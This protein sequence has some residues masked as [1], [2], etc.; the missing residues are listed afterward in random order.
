MT[1]FFDVQHLQHRLIHLERTR[2]RRVIRL[3]R[4]RPMRAGTG[5][6]GTFVAQVRERILAVM[7]IFPIDLESF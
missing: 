5:G 4:L 1:H 2:I 6:A 3:L 7:L